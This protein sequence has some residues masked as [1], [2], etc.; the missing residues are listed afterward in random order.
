MILK[1]IR[2]LDFT[3]Y[4]AGPTT[5]RLMAEMGAEVIKIERAKE[6]DPSRLLPAIK[7]DRSGFFVQQNL[8]KKSLCLDLKSKKASEIITKLVK[9]VDVVLE[10]FGPGVMEKRGWDYEQ[11]RKIN[12]GLVMASISAFGRKSLL[13][14]KTGFDWIAQAFAGIMEMTGPADGPPHPIG[15]GMAD[16]TTGVHAFAAVGY[17]LFNKERTGEGQWSDISMIDCLFHAHEVN[18]QVPQLTDGSFVPKRMGAHHKLLTPCGVFNAPDGYIVILCT[19]GQWAN[20]CAAMQMPQLEA[21]CRFKEPEAR[22]KNQDELIKIIEG[23]MNEMADNEEILERLEANRVPSS[24]VLS[25]TDALTHPYFLDRGTI[26]LTTDRILGEL[27]LPGF[28]LRFS[29]QAIYDPGD[30]PFLGEHNAEILIGILDYSEEDITS[31]YD[32]GVLFAESL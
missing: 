12:P 11:L 16:I 27:K 6:G 14:H 5:S 2:V 8:G 1:G 10:N 32:D 17:A 18:R 30:A 31:L 25:P 26:R 20:L 28:P 7:N 3:Q 15:V 4:L 24:P 22:V 19:Q 23:W 13:S 21:D 9:Q 29:G